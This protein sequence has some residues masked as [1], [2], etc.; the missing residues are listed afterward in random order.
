M[1]HEIKP[2]LFILT[3]ILF[4]MNQPQYSFS[5]IIAIKSVPVA[6]GDQFNIFPSQNVS[7]GSISIALEDRLLD[8]FINPAKGGQLNSSWFYS[9]PSY[10]SIANENGSAKT[11]PVGGFIHKKEWFGG[12]ALAIQSLS[13]PAQNGISSF[14]NSQ[15]LSGESA[16]NQYFYVMY[17]RYLSNTKFSLGGSLFGSNLGA[18]EGV[19][20]LYPRSSK[21]DQEGKIIDVRLGITGKLK[22]GTVLEGLLLFNHFDMTH[23]V[24][25]NDWGWLIDPSNQISQSHKEENLDRTNIWGIHLGYKKPL[26]DTGWQIGTILTTNYMTHPKIPNYELMNIPRDPGT[27]WAYNIGIGAGYQKEALTFGIDFIYEPIWSHTWAEAVVPIE[28][29]FGKII[30]RGEKTVNNNFKFSNSIFR[31][32]IRQEEKSF[33]FQIGLQAR[34]IHYQLKQ[35]DYISINQRKQIETWTEWTP[36]LGFIIKLKDFKIHYDACFITGTGQP[37]VI[38]NQISAMDFGASKANFIVAPSGAL[39]LNEAV[40][41]S[42]RI[43]IIIPIQE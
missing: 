30:Q 12:M 1:K 22:A 41:F 39:T 5:Q 36:S 2:L 34:T 42:H 8:P 21:I 17:G 14:S 25:Y 43:S 19:E 40:V 20:L 15:V 10:Y 4:L 28:N 37:G 11:L 18:M 7:M 38:S 16:G 31:I 29:N 9:T 35:M 27:S 3:I 33:G 24:T 26:N 23:Q 32:G 6:E 13:N